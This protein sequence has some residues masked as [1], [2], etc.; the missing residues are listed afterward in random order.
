MKQTPAHEIHNPDLLALIPIESKKIIEIGCSSGALAREFK[1][2][3]PSSD[4]V[5]IETDKSYLELSKRYCDKSLLLNIEQAS[6]NFWKEFSDR[7]CWVFGDVL[8]HLID[9]WEILKKISRIIPQS[10]V[11][12]ACIPNMQHWSIIARLGVGDLRYENFGLLDKTHLRW[13]TRQTIIEMFDQSGFKIDTH[14][15]RIFNEVNRELFLPIIEQIAK[16]SNVDP[17]IAISDSLSL[18][19][20]IRASKK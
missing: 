7:D 11:V 2:I 10:G 12:V 17:H 1:L 14:I 4:W 6:E 13:F 5:G 3:S 15:P 19:Y 16:F 20:V 9:P 18:Q 8:E